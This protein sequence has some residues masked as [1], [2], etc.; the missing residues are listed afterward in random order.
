MK[1][2]FLFFKLWTTVAAL[3]LALGLL[4]LGVIEWVA[5][6]AG[7]IVI[8][9]AAGFIDHFYKRSPEQREDK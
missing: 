1:K 9:A 8:S 2:S 5:F 4:V 7:L 3:V 6:M